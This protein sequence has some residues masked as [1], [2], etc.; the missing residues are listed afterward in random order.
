MVSLAKDD[1]T[2]VAGKS[3]I[4]HIYDG[5]ASEF[6]WT[7]GEEDFAEKRA[8]FVSL[9]EM[10]AWL[11]AQSTNTADNPLGIKL[12]VDMADLAAPALDNAAHIDPLGRLYAALDGKYVEADLSGST[13]NIVDGSLAYGT[14]LAVQRSNHNRIVKITLPSTLE[15]IGDTAFVRADMEIAYPASL[16]E[17][18][19]YAFRYSTIAEFDF[20]GTALEEIGVGAFLNCPNIESLV[21][22]RSLR[23]FAERPY[24]PSTATNLRAS[25]TP[26]LTDPFSSSSS[27]PGLDA[28]SF[29]GTGPLSVETENFP[30]GRR[31]QY[32]MRTEEGGGK[33]LFYYRVNF[34]DPNTDGPAITIPQG[35]VR[36]GDNL[37]Y[38]GSGFSTVRLSGVVLPDTLEHIGDFAFAGQEHISRID[39]PRGLKTLGRAAFEDCGLLEFLNIG[40]TQ[41][42]S[43]GAFALYTG[44]NVTTDHGRLWRRVPDAESDNSVVVFPPTLKTVG[45]NAFGGGYYFDMSAKL[46]KADFSQTQLTSVG[47]EAFAY[48]KLLEEVVF[49]DTLKSIE[50][51]AFEHCPNLERVNFPPSLETLGAGAFNAAALI[52]GDQTALINRKLR[53]VDL[54]RTKLTRLPGAFRLCVEIDTVRL[55]PTLRYIDNEAFR[56]SGKITTFDI[57]LDSQLESIGSNVFNVTAN[58][59]GGTV[60]NTGLTSLNLPASLKSLG[61]NA[62]AGLAGLA[63][64][65]IPASLESVGSGVFTGCVALEEINVV[66]TGPLTTDSAKRLLIKN[67]VVLTGLSA[68]DGVVNIPEGVT[69][70]GAYAFGATA[71]ADAAKLT[72]A[73]FPSTLTKIGD[74]AFYNCSAYAGSVTIPEGV[75]EIGA[76]AFAGSSAANAVKL[77]GATFPSTLE[78]IGDYAFR[79]CSGLT[80]TI[81]FPATLK[82]IGNYA[83]QYCTGLDTA[84]SF[85]SSSALRSIGNY[86]F[87]NCTAI[88]SIDFSNTALETVGNYAFGNVNS[89]VAIEFPATVKTFGNST[90][91][92]S[93]N[94]DLAITLN[95]ATPPAVG[96]NFISAALRTAGTA[97]GVCIYVPSGS[98]DAY[99]N[100]TAPNWAT[101]KDVITA[102]P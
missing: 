52:G 59:T 85:P 23:G 82:E 53:M 63:S 51:L 91:T 16:K 19:N 84:I 21:I 88:P 47:I 66:G 11:E 74:Y 2:K 72:G 102:K 70:I 22:P 77:T 7:F 97:K 35:V 96:T 24:V 41:V 14:A 100:S 33:T 6:E 27:D 10:A 101:Y 1:G 4:V 71:V 43:I 28:I 39:L 64:I 5:L 93:S 25:G 31:I 69:E 40:D 56:Y 42:E 78:K 62:L 80:G 36:L 20:S 13:G 92:K 73:T 8:Y 58:E 9:E 57:P 81:N 48:C 44:S 38:S 60:V 34:Y 12:S 29:T 54:S 49:P 67:N 87:N 55:P 68:Y 86:A 83:F 17:I 45:D 75:T 37:F 30:D 3:D 15:R 50:M 65:T 90:F 79:F 32:W 46:T 89:L 98:V 61:N 94:A 99:K 26:Q 76:Y 95:S 18:G